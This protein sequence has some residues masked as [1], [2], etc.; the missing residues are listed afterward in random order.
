MGLVAAI[1]LCIDTTCLPTGEYSFNLHIKFFNK[2]AKHDTNTTKD[3]NHTVD[4]DDIKSVH[5]LAVT[6]S[7]TVILCHNI[8][9]II[10]Y[11]IKQS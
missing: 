4:S 8:R 7:K 11:E 5:T 1:S 9:F 3:T 2:H 10:E 6:F